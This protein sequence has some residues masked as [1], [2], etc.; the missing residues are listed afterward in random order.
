MLSQSK[1]HKRLVN[2]DIIIMN[3]A[4]NKNRMKLLYFL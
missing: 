4:D 2:S 1:L 3:T